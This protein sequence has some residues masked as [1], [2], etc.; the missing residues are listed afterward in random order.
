MAARN[1]K[2]LLHR[3]QDPN[4]VETIQDYG[5]TET[6]ETQQFRRA[7]D[8]YRSCATRTNSMKE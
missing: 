3:Q 2:Q 8:L 1:V 4:N 6:M 5:H 7:T